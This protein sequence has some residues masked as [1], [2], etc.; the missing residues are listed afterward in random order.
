MLLNI[1]VNCRDLA[2]SIE[3]RAR[4]HTPYIAFGEIYLKLGLNVGKLGSMSR[5]VENNVM[6]SVTDA[7]QRDSVTVTRNWDTC[8]PVSE[9]N[10]IQI[11]LLA[12][13]PHSAKISTRHSLAA[14]WNGL[15]LVECAHYQ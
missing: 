5:Q 3:A 7:T 4:R 6:R 10:D 1:C 12:F 8:S 14:S 2:D 9:A 13:Y 15:K 11:A